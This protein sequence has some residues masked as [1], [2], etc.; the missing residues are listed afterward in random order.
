MAHRLVSLALLALLP[1]CGGGSDDD[2]DDPGTDGGSVY[3][4]LRVEPTAATLTIDGATPAT[5]AFRAYGTRADGTEE[6]VT[7]RVVW[8][9]D[10]AACRIPLLRRYAWY[11]YFELRA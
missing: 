10:R 11:C 4:E 8:S 6:E 2:D 5:Q 7:S 3:S 9:L 1:A